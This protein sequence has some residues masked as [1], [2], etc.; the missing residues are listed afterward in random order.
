MISRV[1]PLLA[2][3]AMATVLTGCG[4][5]GNSSSS[6]SG[7]TNFEWTLTEGSRYTYDY[8]HTTE[9]MHQWAADE[10]PMRATL[11]MDGSI[12]IIGSAADRGNLNT[13]NTVVRMIDYN[14]EGAPVD[15][16]LQELPSN[17]IEGFAS[18]GSLTGD[19]SGLY[20]NYLFPLP[21]DV[22]AQG[23][24]STKAFT[25]VAKTAEQD[26][27][28]KGTNTLTFTGFEQMNGRNC[29]VLTGDIVFTEVAL[30]EGEVGERSYTVEGK[31]KYYFDVENGLYVKS[32]VEIT[33]HIFVNT[34]IPENDGR[35]Y[36]MDR[37]TVDSYEVNLGGTE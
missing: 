24:T 17:R 33:T 29:A 36:F 35:G 22:I 25:T 1:H 28:A 13:T 34:K 23:G 18:N 31:G 7:A 37:V 2:A 26:Y 15:T 32:S 16:M 8:S 21:P 5:D 14:D 6:S 12:E 27:D 3:L 4:N 9:T 30:P 20:T 11:L 10:E 19:M